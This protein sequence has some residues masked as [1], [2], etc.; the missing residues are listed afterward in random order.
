MILLTYLLKLK[1]IF[2]KVES[3]KL[4]TVA[5]KLSKDIKLEKPLV[6]FNISATGWSL[7]TDKIIKIAYVK[8]WKEGRVK[9]DS[10]LLNPEIKISKESSEINGRKNVELKKYSTFK[11][12]AQ[13]IWDIFNSCCYGGFNIV[14]FDL[15]MLKREF[16]R[17]GMDFNYSTA[18]I[19]D[20]RVVHEHMEPWTLSGAYKFYC[21]KNYSSY[22]RDALN[23][24]EIMAEILEKQIKDYRALK[25]WDFVFRVHNTREAKHEDTRKKFYWKKGEAHFAFSKYRDMPLSKVAKIDPEFLKWI[26]GADFS[27]ET[28]NIAGIALRNA[29]KRRYTNK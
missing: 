25:D 26:I 23:D 8:I 24:V 10:I 7:S 18:N 5:K 15:P 20:S 17:V 19:I 16:L 1:N 28:K 21:K 13:E 29:P 12:R 3:N 14:N 27:E 6:I 22:S 4:E 11:K 9:K 2:K